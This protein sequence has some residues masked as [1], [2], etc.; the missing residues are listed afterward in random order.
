MFTA[1]SVE[2]RFFAVSQARREAYVRLWARSML[3][4]L[5]VQ[6]VLDAPEG[7]PKERGVP[8]LVVANHR[9]TIDILLMLHLFGGQLLAR[10]DMATWPGIGALARRAGTLFVDRTDPR[11]GAAAV[12]S[13]RERMR[14]GITVSVFPEGTTFEGDEVR[15]FQAGAFLAI[16]REKGRVLPVGVA[17]EHPDAIYGDEP[18]GR[19]MKRLAQAPATRVGIAVGRLVDARGTAVLALA[20]DAQRQVQTLVEKARCL[21]GGAS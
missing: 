19:H 10:G 4:L 14:G 8:M 21:V 15:P 17:Y 11:S 5:G 3:G 1:L 6:I 18:V 20:S 12:R 7:M 2:E 9:S 13:M 16:A